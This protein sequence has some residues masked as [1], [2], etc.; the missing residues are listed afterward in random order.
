MAREN[1]AYNE[2]VDEDKVFIETYRN[3]IR[4]LI[5]ERSKYKYG[6]EMYDKL[7]QYISVA[8]EQLKDAEI[9]MNE[10]AQGECARR[11]KNTALF[12]TLGTVAGNVLGS[13]IGALINRKN[14]KT[15]VGIE[16]AGE[17]VNS[18]AMK[19]VK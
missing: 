9:A 5:A 13:T 18:K 10:R 16:N 14:V 11:N 19:F 8:T 1:E 7:T 15:V 6:E 17:I 12:Q 3:D 2:E 4:R